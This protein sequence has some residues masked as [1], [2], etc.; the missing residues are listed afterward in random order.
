MKKVFDDNYV[1]LNCTIVDSRQNFL[2]LLT[3]E[4]IGLFK[5]LSSKFMNSNSGYGQKYS[6]PGSNITLS[7]WIKDLKKMS[8]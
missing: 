4:M 2:F 3:F 5:K 6:E 7:M 8:I 1:Y